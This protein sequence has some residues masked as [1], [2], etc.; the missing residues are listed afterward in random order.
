[1]SP[2]QPLQSRG[3][4]SPNPAHTL[5]P[6]ATTKT[7][8]ST[9]YNRNFA[10]HL[11]DHQIHPIYSSHEPDLTHIT[12][13]LAVP[14]RSLSPSEFSD[15]AFKA[16]KEQSYRAKDEGD[17][18]AGVVPTILGPQNPGHPATW[19]TVF[20]NLEHLTDGT[21]VPA[22]PDIYYG[23]YPEQLVR[24][25]REKLSYHIVPSPVHDKPIAP[26]F[27]LEVKGPDGSAAVAA[28]QARY[29]GAIGSRAMHSLQNYGKEEPIYDNNAYTFSFTF[30]DGFLKLYAHHPTAPTTKGGPP[31]Y[32]MTQ[33]DAWGLTGNVDTFRRGA[34]AFRNA[35]DL[36]KRH[37][38]RFI[39][40][41]NTVARD[42]W[43]QNIVKSPS[44]PQNLPADKDFPNASQASAVPNFG[45][46]HRSFTPSFSSIQTSAK[47]SRESNSPPPSSTDNHRAKRRSR[48]STTRE[49]DADAAK[50]NEVG[51]YR[52]SD[53]SDSGGKG[54]CIF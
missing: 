13:A 28:R 49:L 29:D 32:H 10:Q 22:K 37:R 1:M 25:V 24:S 11:T 30:C 34:T 26:N 23:T 42:I 48:P 52:R 33:V 36:A 51:T 50:P 31:Q 45:E 14:R 53:G 18:L 44:L 4:Q 20:R 46:R 21:I 6:S 39:Q 43:N 19:N 38:D 27:F 16:F 47:R 35:R 2:S 12:K 9:P 5:P 40:D 54:C 15:N 8:K 41:A 3:T 7:K 17:T